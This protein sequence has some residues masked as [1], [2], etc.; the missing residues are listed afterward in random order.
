MKRPK[1][2]NLINSPKGMHDILPQ[3]QPIWERIRKVAK[4]I[5]DSYNFLRLDTPIVE[6]ASLYERPLGAG[7]DVVEKQMFILNTKGGDGLAL[8]P[9][10]T[11]GVSRAYLQHGLSHLAQPL[12]LYY[13]SR[14]FGCGHLQVG[15]FL[16]FYQTGFEIIGK[17][18]QLADAHNGTS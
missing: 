15:R 18:A 6:Y 10:G 14:M 9:E 16:Q 2:K 3:D 8:R 17:N 13:E 1:N 7:S 11:A 12:K 4:D 5:S